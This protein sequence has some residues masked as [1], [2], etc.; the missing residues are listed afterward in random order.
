MEYAEEL[1][2][3]NKTKYRIGKISKC[4]KIGGEAYYSW[5]FL[6]LFTVFMSLILAGIVVAA[7]LNSSALEDFSSK[8]EEVVFLL[9]VSL[10]V[11]S[12]VYAAILVFC[13]ILLVR[14]ILF[15][16]LILEGRVTIGLVSNSAANGPVARGGIQ[17]YIIEYVYLDARNRVVGNA[18]KAAIHHKN[19]LV[20][21][22]K[23]L[24]VYTDKKSVILADFDLQK[25]GDEIIGDN[26]HE[27]EKLTGE[28]IDKH[29]SQRKVLSNPSNEIIGLKLIMGLGIIAAV[30]LSL[31]SIFVKFQD[32][33]LSVRLFLFF[34]GIGIGILS[35][36]I[37][38]FLLQK[39]S[40]AKEGDRK[41]AD[42]A[43]ITNA[44]I[45]SSHIFREKIDKFIY[46]YFIDAR[47]VR[48][49][50]RRLLDYKN[51]PPNGAL[52]AYNPDNPDE[53][54]LIAA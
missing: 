34:T 44:V 18:V 33:S 29:V 16:K 15:K 5:L 31:F 30:F 47:G 53:N 41:L 48:R 46:Y 21:V 45:V 25:I 19:N 26:A 49:M 3:I 37:S 42:G 40:R 38:L 13:I 20:N 51:I 54:L 14:S 11:L 52:V 28:L 43:S 4:K 17:Q 36:S 2:N 32:D 8:R 12:P 6:L 50:S 35:V 23:V 7:G 10:S 1:K 22:R 24:V 9:T 27:I 39:I